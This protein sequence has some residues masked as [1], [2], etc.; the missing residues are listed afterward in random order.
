MAVPAVAVA[1]QTLLQRR[2]ELAT[3]SRVSVRDKLPHTVQREQ[4]IMS[5]SSDWL[6]LVLK[7]DFPPHADFRESAQ[8]NSVEVS[9]VL[10]GTASRPCHSGPLTIVVDQSVID[11]WIQAPEPEQ[12]FITE[13]VRAVIQYGRSMDEHVKHRDHTGQM[14]VIRC[15]MVDVWLSAP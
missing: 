13:R 1:E 6:E 7:S 11:R 2:D 14:T 8:P 3:V 15:D 10:D 4:A 12:E 9:W 5:A